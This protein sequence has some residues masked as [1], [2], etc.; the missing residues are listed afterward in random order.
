[1]CLLIKDDPYLGDGWGCCRCKTY[2]GIHRSEC[3]A[4]DHT[5]CALGLEDTDIIEPRDVLPE[6]KR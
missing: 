6:E 4:C 5:P 2:N 1:M 3:K